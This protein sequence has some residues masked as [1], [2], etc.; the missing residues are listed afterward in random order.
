MAFTEADLVAVEAAIAK[1]ESYVQFQDR[2]VTYRSVDDLREARREILKGIAD[3]AAAT[4]GNAPRSRQTL[5][6]GS[7]GF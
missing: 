7:K 2:A 3:E 5:I 1:G 6:V 4:A